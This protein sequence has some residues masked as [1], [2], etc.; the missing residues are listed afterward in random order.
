MRS[1]HGALRFPFLGISR[2]KYYV[3]GDPKFEEKLDEISQAWKE[4]GGGRPADAAARLLEVGGA[5]FLKVSW[6]AAAA[7]GS[8]RGPWPRRP[9][10]LKDYDTYLARYTELHARR[11]DICGD[12]PQYLRDPYVVTCFP[13]CPFPGRLARLRASAGPKRPLA[14]IFGMPP[15]H[16]ALRLAVIDGEIHER[17]RGRG[18]PAP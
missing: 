1:E 13:A 8:G 16:L 15:H 14:T 10:M 11:R 5:A 17:R 3:D 7:Q 18:R 12:C 6:V 2:E 9:L 4:A